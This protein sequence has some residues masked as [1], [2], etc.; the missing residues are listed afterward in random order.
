MVGKE[1]VCKYK[2]KK[3]LI[4]IKKNRSIYSKMLMHEKLMFKKAVLRNPHT[5]E[6]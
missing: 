2:N 5:T 3:R 1:L 6:S 4:C